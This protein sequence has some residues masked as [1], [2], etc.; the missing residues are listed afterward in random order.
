M[1]LTLFRNLFAPPRDLILVVIAIWIGAWLADKRADRHAISPNAL[2]KITFYPLL[3]YVLGGR[4]LYVVENIQGFIQSPRDIFSLNL[5]LFDSWGG[6][7]V[8][9]VTA[10][11]IMNRENLSLWPVL[12]ALTPIFAVGLIGFSLANVASGHAFGSETALPWAI[13]LWGA[14]RHPSQ[15]YAALASFLTF[16]LLWFQKA[17]T[18]PGVHFLTFSA[19][20][21]GWMLFLEAFRGDSLLVFAGLRVTQIVAWLVLALSLFLLDRKQGAPVEVKEER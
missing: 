11:V 1:M 8:A 9:L 5:E 13:D 10:F 12:D 14:S 16:V 21:S 7:G 4:L 6:L 3:A 17:D 20:T 2:E 19:L 18:P 15:L